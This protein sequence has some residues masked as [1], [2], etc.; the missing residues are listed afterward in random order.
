IPPAF[1]I[2]GPANG[3]TKVSSSPSISWT[4]SAGAVYYVLHIGTTNPPPAANDQ[5]V[6]ETI[7]NPASGS[8][9]P[10][11]G[12]TTYFW[13]VDA[14]GSIDFQTQTPIKTSGT[15]GVFHFT[16]IADTTPP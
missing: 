15:G 11:L 14:F 2:A 6:L 13:S 1:Q 16:T 8:M 3:A 7:F 5:R 10:L 4:L 12:S 9:G